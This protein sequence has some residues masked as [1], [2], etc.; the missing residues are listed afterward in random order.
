[1]YTAVLISELM[2]PLVYSV[3]VLDK[4]NKAFNQSK[5]I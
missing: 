1:M 3:P 5:A 2:Q 4:K